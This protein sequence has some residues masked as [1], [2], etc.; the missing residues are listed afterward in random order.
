ME[1]NGAKSD[2]PL[3][4]ESLE[5]TFSLGAREHNRIWPK[6][7]RTHTHIFKKHIQKHPIF[8]KHPKFLSWQNWNHPI[9]QINAVKPSLVDESNTYNYSVSTWNIKHT[10]VAG[11]LQAAQAAGTSLPIGRSHGQMLPRE[12]HSNPTHMFL[13][14]FLM[15]GRRGQ[16]SNHEQIKEKRHWLLYVNLSILMEIHHVCL[17]KPRC[18]LAESWSFESTFMVKDT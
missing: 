10:S 6:Q 17:C 18:P 12:G 2:I 8:T 9:W 14:T 16:L 13:F 4:S 7:T 1:S 5:P 11:N 15:G 3:R